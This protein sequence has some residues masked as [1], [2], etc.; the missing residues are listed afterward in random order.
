MITELYIVEDSFKY[1]DS[2]TKIEIVEKLKLLAGDYDYIRQYNTEKVYYHKDIFNVIIYP[3]YTIE[4]FLY[5]PTSKKD[6]SRNALE[7]LRNIIRKSKIKE[8]TTKEVIEILFNEQS[9]ETIHGLLGLHKIK[10]IDSKYIIY[11]K[12][13]WLNFHRYFLGIFP[14]N[15]DYYIE[16]CKKYFPN[17]FFHENCKITVTKIFN[18]FVKSIINHLT[19]LNDIFFYLRDEQFANESE[20]YKALK[21]SCNLEEKIASKD[22]NDIKDK[23]TFNFINSEKQKTNLIC[24]P[25][26]RLSH[27]DNYPGDSKYYFNRIYFHEGIEKIEKRKILI[28]HIGEHR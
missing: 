10:E 2:I 23:L 15:P 26:L 8:I 5:D 14:K 17:L 9:E 25:H 13:N 20:K 1:Q 27:S 12:N 19:C 6:F 28:G 22:K 24:Y 11:R 18:N 21:A 7:Y 16:E 4:K 3:G